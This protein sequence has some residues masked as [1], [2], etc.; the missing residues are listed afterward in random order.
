MGYIEGI[1][2]DQVGFWSFEDMV[3]EESMVRVIDRF[4][5]I[6]DLKQKGFTRIEP[7]D[8]GRPGYSPKPLVKLLV[9]GYENGI[10]ASRKLEAECKRNVEV[11][12]LMDGLKP[13]HK[14]IAEFRR[15]NIRPL[16]K[17]FREFVVLCRTWDMVGGEVFAI[18]GTKIKASNNKKNIF[19]K[20]KLEERIERIDKKVE[21]WFSGAEAE[22]TEDDEAERKDSTEEDVLAGLME[23]KALYEQHLAGLEETGQSEVSLVDPDA[24]LMATNRGGVDAAYNV[25]ST[26]DAKHHL[27]VDFDVSMSA[28]DLGQL[29]NMVKRLIRL[30]YRKFTTLEDKGYYKG[31]DLEKCEKR[32]VLAIGARQA[33]P[34][35]KGR[36]KRFAVDR[37][38]YDKTTDTYQCPEGAVLSSVSAKDTKQ[39]KYLNKEACSKCAHVAT[40]TG[41]E[42]KHRFILRGEYAD[43]YDRADQTFKD[44]P[45]L[46]AL[47]QQTV[48]HPFGTVKRTQD[49]YYFLLRTRR[50]VRC[51]VALMLLGYNLKRAVKELGFKEIM[52]R[53][54]GL[55]YCFSQH[56]PWKKGSAGRNLRLLL[57]NRSPLGQFCGMSRIGSP[58]TAT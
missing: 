38:S 42:D 6:L 53:L 55:A 24:R 20:E 45:E 48:E 18:D 41:G 56:M 52:A 3:G 58:Q 32:K 54:D 31:A 7:K 57:R 8:T 26:V 34:S 5:D 11:M 47:R 10:R 30:G 14:T 29:D 16:Q 2:R 15:M 27:V 37:F 22:D 28:A 51:E 46:Y 35:P 36:P 39:R 1:H 21:E 19:S 4:V 9:Y 13:V 50:K 25:Q 40:C 44:N 23:R 43:V 12:W 49:G 33:P 17:L